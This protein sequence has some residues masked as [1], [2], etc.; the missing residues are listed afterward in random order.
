MRSWLSPTAWWKCE[1]TP[2]EASWSPNQAELVSAIWPSRSSVPTA[3]IS[4]LTRVASLEARR[5]SIRYWNPVARVRAAATQIDATC[6]VW[7]LASGGM[8]QVADRPVLDER[9]QLGRVPGRDGDAPSTHPRAVDLHAD[10][11]DGDEDDREPGQMPLRGQGEERTE[12]DR[13]VGQGVQ[14]GPGPGGAL[15]AGHVPIEPVAAGDDQ[16]DDHVE[17][18]RPP[19]HDHGHEDRRG[20]QAGHGHGVGRRGQG[21]RPEREDAGRGSCRYRSPRRSRQGM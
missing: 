19:D 2:A 10:L 20:Q 11:A 17:P 15:A 18:G 8:M 9:L 4:T 1:V 7:L 13:L 21:G 5:P 12:H 16:A 3:T 6:T 14:E